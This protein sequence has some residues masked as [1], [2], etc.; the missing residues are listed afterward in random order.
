MYPKG[1]ITREDEANIPEFHSHEEARAWFKAQYGDR[2]MLTG[3]QE[4]G[5]GS[6][7][8]Y[9]LILDAEK[10]NEFQRRMAEDGVLVGAMELMFSYQSIEIYSDGRIHVI[11]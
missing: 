5:D 8:F 9:N 2:F 7:Y 4:D 10:F 1:H 11:H 6:V 3:S